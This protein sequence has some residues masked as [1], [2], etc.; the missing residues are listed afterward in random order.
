MA[1]KTYSPKRVELIIN[2]VP[3]KG[4]ADGTFISVERSSDAF[5][6]NVGADGEVS[7]THSSDKTGKVTLTLQQTSES[8][9]FLSALVILDEETLLGQFALLLKDTNGTTI[10]ES[11][12]AWIDKVANTE[13]G[14]EIS[15]REWIIS[16]S[17]LVSFVGGNN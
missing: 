16:C 11:P 2:G 10:C 1:T 6:T 9:D 7:R 15:D 13:F 14:A 4:F 8:N 5:S 17:E 12:S 3:M